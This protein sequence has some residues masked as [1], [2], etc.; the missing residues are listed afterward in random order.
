M[1]VEICNILCRLYKYF[2]LILRHILHFIFG[3]L[4]LAGVSPLV[5]LFLIVGCAARP[6]YPLPS[7]VADST[8]K[9][10]QTSRP[11]NLAHRGSN[12]ELPEETAPAY[13]VI[14]GMPPP[15]KF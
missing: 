6:F 2:H 3:I 11:Y 8:R 13:M 14:M 15:G 7:K 5:I 9:P 10:L 4:H 12:G 1:H